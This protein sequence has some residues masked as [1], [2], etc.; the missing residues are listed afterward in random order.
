MK[1]FFEAQEYRVNRNFGISAE[2]SAII[3]KMSIKFGQNSW[4]RSYF[5]VKKNNRQK[6]FLPEM[7]ISMVLL[8]NKKNSNICCFVAKIF[9]FVVLNLEIEKI[10][11]FIAFGEGPARAPW[12][13]KQT[14]L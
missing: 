3:Q 11:Y 4:K 5:T 13:K 14:C 6:P 7:D 10:S 8:K 9:Q 2:I 1:F 12:K